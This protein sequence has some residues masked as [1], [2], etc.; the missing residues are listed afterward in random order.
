ME[1]AAADIEF[2]DGVVTVAGTDRRMTIEEVAKASRD[3]AHLEEGMTPG[4][5]E[6]HECRP[7]AATFPNGCHVCEVEIDPDTGAM[8]IE[9]YTIVDDFGV[10]INP[11]LLAGQVHGGSAQGFSTEARREGKECVST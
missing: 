11:A 3:P 2:A 4:L 1:A 5:D 10:T 8:Q 7:E 6:I 9:R